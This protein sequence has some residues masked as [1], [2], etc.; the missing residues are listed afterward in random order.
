[1]RL[2]TGIPSS[3]WNI[4]ASVTQMLA[5]QST[6]AR[7]GV[8]IPQV[9][10]CGYNYRMCDKAYC[11]D[12]APSVERDVFCD[13]CGKQLSPGEPTQIEYQWPAPIPVSER[14]PEVGDFVMWYENG[15]WT[16]GTMGRCEN[17]GRPQFDFDAGDPYFMPE[18][19]GY[20]MVLLK[21]RVTHWLP[22]PPAP[23][24]EPSG[25][26]GRAGSSASSSSGR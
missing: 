17:G 26:I 13:G 1:M 11:G 18:Y 24:F 19:D 15:D 8:F 21:H 14:L 6:L 23:T 22:I 3:V 4:C 10:F 9:E 5:F 16:V 25:P 7:N 2:A 12:C 20:G